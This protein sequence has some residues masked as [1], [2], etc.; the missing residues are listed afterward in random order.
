MIGP[1]EREQKTYSVSSKLTRK[2]LVNGENDKPKLETFT[3]NMPDVTTLEGTR[4]E[5]HSGGKLNGTPFGFQLRVEVR[6]ASGDKVRFAVT[7]EDSGAEGGVLN[8]LVRSH[9]QEEVHQ[10]RLGQAITLE[11]DRN[12]RGEAPGWN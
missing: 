11:L 2:L 8:T 5:Y 10:V 6:L 9:R 3:S 1:K 12:D 7:V 4:G